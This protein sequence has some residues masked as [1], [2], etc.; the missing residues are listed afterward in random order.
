VDPAP[1]LAEILQDHKRGV[2]AREIS[3]RFHG[4]LVEFTT[5]ICQSVRE[6]EGIRDVALSGGVFQNMLLLRGLSRR[7]R[8]EGFKVHTHSKVPT[9][10]GGISLG[11]LLAA[12]TMGSGLEL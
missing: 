8:E 2:S 5:E 9:N 3:R 10:D 1:L 4:T 12:N 11:Q 6:R 7:L